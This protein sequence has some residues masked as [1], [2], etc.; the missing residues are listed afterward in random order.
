MADDDKVNKLTMNVPQSSEKRKK[1]NKRKA[2]SAAAA[3]AE[4]L[5]VPI[6]HHRCK[7]NEQPTTLR[8][9]NCSSSLH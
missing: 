6:H 7:T 8:T 2:K 5:R 1:K 3:G 4:I 9:N